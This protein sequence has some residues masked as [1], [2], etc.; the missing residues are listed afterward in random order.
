[1]AK[2]RSLGILNRIKVNT[3]IRRKKSGQLTEDPE[4]NT[5]IRPETRL[6]IGR[7]RATTKK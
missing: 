6:G 2:V 5:R 3:R 1:M 4:V 7:D